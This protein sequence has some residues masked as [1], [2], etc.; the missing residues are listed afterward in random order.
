MPGCVPP[1]VLEV[2][3][4]SVLD[5]M[6]SLARVALVSDLRTWVSTNCMKMSAKVFHSALSWA[7]ISH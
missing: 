2:Q 6:L 3:I 7:R 5:A 1:E 4:S